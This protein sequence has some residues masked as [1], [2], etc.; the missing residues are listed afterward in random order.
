[1]KTPF[2]AAITF[3]LTASLTVPAFA[4][5]ITVTGANGGS[6]TSQGSCQSGSGGVKCASNT[7]LTAPNGKTS[8]RARVTTA[9]HGQITSTLSGTRINGKSFGRSVKASR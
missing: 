6:L 4:E 3:A 5:N 8:T 2:I 7:T 1:M 9:A